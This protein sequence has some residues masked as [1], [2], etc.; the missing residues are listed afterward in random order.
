MIFLLPPTLLGMVAVG[1]S[2][3][4]AE[5]EKVMDRSAD[6]CNDFYQYSCGGWQVNKSPH[7]TPRHTCI[8]AATIATAAAATT[9]VCHD[10][11]FLSLSLSLSLSH[12][13]T[14]TLTLFGTSS[15]CAGCNLES[16]SDIVTLIPTQPNPTTL[17][18]DVN[19]KYAHLDF[20]I[21]RR[22]VGLPGCHHSCRRRQSIACLPRW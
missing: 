10:C 1:A 22:Q 7:N 20:V 5:V 8:T 6:P 16:R 15:L 19:Y 9:T 2:P 17:L 18:A 4:A 12:I 21:L 3:F 14:L 11:P 13:H